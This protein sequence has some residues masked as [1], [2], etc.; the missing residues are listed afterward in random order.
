MFISSY[1]F[2][3]LTRK[4]WDASLTYIMLIGCYHLFSPPLSFLPLCP[5]LYSQA[6]P[7]QVQKKGHYYEHRLPI[8]HSHNFRISK[9]FRKNEC[10][11]DRCLLP[12]NSIHFTNAKYTCFCMYP[13]A[14]L[15]TRMQ[16]MLNTLSDT[17]S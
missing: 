5:I 8:S 11:F 1:T 17:Y 14:I 10:G 3:V 4:T 16:D 13:Q 9:F 12:H 2:E 7:G 15:T 6:P